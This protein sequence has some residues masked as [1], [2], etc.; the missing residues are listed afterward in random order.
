MFA[1]EF[2]WPAMIRELFNVPFFTNIFLGPS[3][4]LRV[5]H[6]LIPH[7]S[8]CVWLNCS[9]IW[10]FIFRLIDDFN[11]A[12][13]F[14]WS[15]L[16]NDLF[17]IPPLQVSSWVQAKSYAW[18]IIWSHIVGVVFD[19]TAHEFSNY[20]HEGAWWGRNIVSFHFV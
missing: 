10:S 19:L 2:S 8:R 7:C 3:K 17:N 16:T 13:E 18:F 9:R 14:F 4:E 12:S 6:H 1:F 20:R 15:L 5:I 11:I